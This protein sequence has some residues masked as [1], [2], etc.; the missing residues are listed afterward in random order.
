VGLLAVAVQVMAKGVMTIPETMMTVLLPKA[1]EDKTGRPEL[2]ARCARLT[3]LVCAIL[4][5][6][7]AASATP[8]VRLLFSPSFVPVVSLIRILAVGTLVRC[9]C[10]VFTPYLQGMNHPGIESFAVAMG[11]VVNL[12]ALLCLLPVI[13][14]PAAALSITLSYLTSSAIVT[15]GFVRLSRLDCRQTFWL[16]RSDLAVA[17]QAISRLLPFQ[18]RWVV[19]HGPANPDQ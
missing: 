3:G 17:H 10:K 2:I 14:L 18:R 9:T 5:L 4:I 19:G 11:A 13:G 8:I 1:S 16:S 15:L 6:I 7:I 12:V